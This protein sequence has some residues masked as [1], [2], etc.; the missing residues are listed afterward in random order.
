MTGIAL[1]TIP[2][3]A[4]PIP[5]L[6][7]PV[8][9][10]PLLASS[11]DGTLVS[12]TGDT[13]NR[14]DVSSLTLPSSRVPNQNPNA[15]PNSSSPQVSSVN[16]PNEMGEPNDNIQNDIIVNTSPDAA[17]SHIHHHVH[18]HHYH[19]SHPTNRVHHFGNPHLQITISP[20]MV[21]KNLSL[22]FI[23]LSNGNTYVV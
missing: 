10:N 22:A 21:I 7:I 6:S 16:N 13:C 20:Q 2:G 5:P 23:F 12:S 15:R 1:H 18:Q 17:H 8:P 14:F 3:T 9:I 4:P 19:H 11:S